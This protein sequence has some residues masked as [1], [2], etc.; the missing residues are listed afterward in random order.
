MIFGGSWGW[1]F[2]VVMGVQIAALWLWDNKW[3]FLLGGVVG[4]LAALWVTS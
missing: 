4:L 1:R 3:G 2:N